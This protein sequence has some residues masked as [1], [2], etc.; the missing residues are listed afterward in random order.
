MA[1]EFIN[2]EE[3]DESSGDEIREAKPG[4]YVLLIVDQQADEANQRQWFV[5]DIAEGDDAGFYSTDFYKDKPYA[6]RV[7]ISMKNLGFAKRKLQTISESNPG[8]DA[9]AALRNP[10][11]F[12]GKV[13]GAGVG[14]EERENKTTGSRYFCHD[15]FH[16]NMG[17]AQDARAGKLKVPET[18]H[19]EPKA[20]DSDD[21][22]DVPF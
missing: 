15:F 13:F 8:F 10:S 4:N 5:V 16:A 1:W 2:F 6:H 20:D 12:V 21:F 3:V 11:L 9:L 19:L 7:M 18:V 22:T 14:L 17:T